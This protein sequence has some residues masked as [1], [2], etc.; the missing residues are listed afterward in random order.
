MLY[1]I[2]RPKNYKTYLR[3]I[4][5]THKFIKF[6]FH[7]NLR[8]QNSTETRMPCVDATASTYCPK[9]WKSSSVPTR[10]SALPK[11]LRCRSVSLLLLY[12]L[13]TLL[14]DI[15]E[16]EMFT[17]VQHLNETCHVD[18]KGFFNNTMDNSLCLQ[19]CD[20]QQLGKGCTTR[21]RNPPICSRSFRDSFS[22]PGVER[23]QHE[24]E[25]ISTESVS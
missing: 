4:N 3:P 15:L 23:S 7:K 16:P 14:F 19:D 25:H 12:L 24:A 11:R 20:T 13:T 5:V 17:F 21:F 2:N 8:M 9:V 10:N 6:I 22:L 18:N 1:T